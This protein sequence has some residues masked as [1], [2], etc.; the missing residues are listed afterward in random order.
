MS[1]DSQCS[2]A[3]E[4]EQAMDDRHSPPLILN[5]N[6]IAK[7]QNLDSPLQRLTINGE[8]LFKSP[9]ACGK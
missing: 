7:R 9:A 2:T 1:Y 5:P 8:S 4:S 6:L 3:S